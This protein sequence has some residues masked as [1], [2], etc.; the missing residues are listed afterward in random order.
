MPTADFHPRFSPDGSRIAIA[1]TLGQG[2]EIFVMNSDGTNIHQVTDDGYINFGPA[3]S[4]DGTQLVYTSYRG[5]QSLF[6][7]NVPGSPGTPSPLPL[8]HW[9]LVKLDLGSGAQT[10]IGPANGKPA[11]SAVW[12]PD[13]TRIASASIGIEGQTDIFVESANGTGWRILQGTISTKETYL[14]WR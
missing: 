7:V 1:S 5:S 13:G 12:S 3:W 8:D 6:E 9:T 10:L 11:W 14:D 2:T 4:P